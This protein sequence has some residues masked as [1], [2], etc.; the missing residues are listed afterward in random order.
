MVTLEMDFARRMTMKVFRTLAAALLLLAPLAARAAVKLPPPPT[1]PPDKLSDLYKFFGRAAS[2]GL[3]EEITVWPIKI[4]GRSWELL[5]GAQFPEVDLTLKPFDTQ[6]LHFEKAELLFRRLQLDRDQLL[7]WKLDVRECREVQTRLVFTLRS[8]ARKLSKA[9]GQEIRLKSDMDDR[10]VVLSGPGRFAG[11][12]CEVTARCQPQWD[13]K[14]K[15]LRLVALEQRFGERKVPR[16]LWWL[17]SS[18]VPQAPV[19]DLGFS[20]IPF[21]I[22]EVHV[23]WDHV[24]LSTNW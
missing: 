24:N 23:G 16:W 20:W 3:G 13:E 7:N 15:T 8:L 21:N 11:V 19:L 2:E 1:R 10:I 12:A 17:G 18:P 5:K 4:L 6:E 9:A 22:Q 14:A